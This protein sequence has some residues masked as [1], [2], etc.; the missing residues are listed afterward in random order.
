MGAWLC[1]AHGA[2]GTTHTARDT[3]HAPAAGA[4]HTHMSHPHACRTGGS[5]EQETCKQAS[6]LLPR[7]TLSLR[8]GGASRGR[9]HPASPLSLISVPEERVDV[10]MRQA[11]LELEP[12]P[13]QDAGVLGCASALHGARGSHRNDGAARETKRF[14]HIQRFQRLQHCFDPPPFHLDRGDRDGAG[15]VCRRDPNPPSTI[16]TL[17]RRRINGLL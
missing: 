9:S 1:T 6:P 14:T 13:R 15:A 2:A 7:L 12:E 11:E 17:G 5:L 3:H 8:Q 4:R 10:T 16:P